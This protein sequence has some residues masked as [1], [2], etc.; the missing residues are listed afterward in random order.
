MFRKQCRNTERYSQGFVKGQQHLID[1]GPYSENTIVAGDCLEVMGQ[2]PD[3]CVDLVVTDP[4]FTLPVYT[5]ASRKLIRNLGDFSASSCQM[6]LVFAELERV[7]KP[8]GRLFVF[9]DANF[10]PVLFAATYER[11]YQQL[12]VWDKGRI[13][14]GTDFRKQFELILYLRGH[15]APPLDRRNNKPDVLKC[16]PVPSKERLIEPQKPI[17]LILELLDGMPCELLFDP[18]IGSGTTAVAA[19]RL[20]R[21]FFGCDINPSYVRMALERLRRDRESR[22]QL[23]LL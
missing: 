20:G 17:S 2:M 22:A 21:R 18:F 19:D 14:F 16:K 15:G 8:T 9:C 12:L 10:Y 13:G 7:T 1:L 4:L 5:A 23:E 3:E 11:W 6:S